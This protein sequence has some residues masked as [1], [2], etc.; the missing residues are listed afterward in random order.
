MPTSS[1]LPASALPPLLSPVA[2][3]LP[4]GLPGL[5]EEDWPTVEVPPA[6]ADDAGDPDGAAD[7]LG[8][9]ESSG[10]DSA[11]PSPCSSSS[12]AAYL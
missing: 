11:P 1:R 4:H 8:D 7:C 2:S 6:D 12:E 9:G 3:D 10:D 5:W